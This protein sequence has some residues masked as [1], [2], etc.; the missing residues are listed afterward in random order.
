MSDHLPPTEVAKRL[1]GDIAEI[2]KICDLNPKSFYAYERSSR[3]RPA[4]YFP[5][6]LVQKLILH[7]DRVGAQI[8]ERFLI[9]GASEQELK[10]Y[11]AEAAASSDGA[12]MVAE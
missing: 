9:F 5:L 2:E 8:P 3:T 10:E 4:G 12:P 6:H 11:T 1:I 7:C